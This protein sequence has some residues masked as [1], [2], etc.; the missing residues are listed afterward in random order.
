MDV[1]AFMTSLRVIPHGKRG[2]LDSIKIS[3]GL[4]KVKKGSDDLTPH[5]ARADLLTSGNEG[6]TELLFNTICN[7]ARALERGEWSLPKSR[8]HQTREFV[9]CIVGGSSQACV[10]VGI[11]G[12]RSIRNVHSEE[13]DPVIEFF[14]DDSDAFAIAMQATYHLEST[15]QLK[16]ERFTGAIYLHGP[17][18]SVTQISKLGNIFKTNLDVDRELCPTGRGFHFLIDLISVYYTLEQ[19]NSFPTL[20]PGHRAIAAVGVTYTLINTDYL[21]TASYGLTRYIG[22]PQPFIHEST[23]NEE[24]FGTE[25]YSSRTK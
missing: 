20:P 12:K 17:R 6:F 23:T 11:G 1:A 13:I 15:C 25:I 24:D 19:N 3:R 10:A 16:Q 9:L 18:K 5:G 8:Y 2:K 7:Q 21:K 22:P 4:S 14:S